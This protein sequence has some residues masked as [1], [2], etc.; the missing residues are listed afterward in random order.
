[1]LVRVRTAHFSI[2]ARPFSYSWNTSC[3][4]SRYGFC[5]FFSFILAVLNVTQGARTPFASSLDSSCVE[6][7]HYSITLILC[8]QDKIGLLEHE[9]LGH[10]FEI[11]KDLVDGK[12]PIIPD[13]TR[14]PR[15]K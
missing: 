14:H 9:K 15:I 11:W 3:R 12:I 10:F 6:I 4:F 5:F 2:D 1:M 7:S 8:S 13:G